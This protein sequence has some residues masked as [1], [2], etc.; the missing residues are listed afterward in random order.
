ME[1]GDSLVVNIPEISA[2]CETS[3][4]MASATMIFADYGSFI[5]SVINTRVKDVHLRND[6]YH[7]FFLSLVRNPI[8]DNISNIKSYLYKAICNDICDSIRKLKCYD[9]HIQKHG[10]RKGIYLSEPPADERLTISDEACRMFEII[11][12]NLTYG[13]ANVIKLKYQ[14]ELNNNEI[15]ESL[16][17]GGPSVSTYFSTGLKKLRKIINNEERE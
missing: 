9:R 3:E 4:N 17:I 7:D 13:E 10:Q 6:V 14:K 5:R 11:E 1:A 2:G 8:P 12:T 16:N 15:A